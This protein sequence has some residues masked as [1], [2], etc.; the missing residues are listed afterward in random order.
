MQFSRLSYSW[1]WAWPLVRALLVFSCSPLPAANWT[2]SENEL[3]QS[4]IADM[5]S[6]RKALEQSRI[7]LADSRENATELSRLLDEA[8]LRV[9]RLS[10]QLQLWQEHSNELTQSL[11]RLSV[12]LATLRQELK[13]LTD[14]YNALSTLHTGYVTAVDKQILGLQRSRDVWRVVGLGAIVAA[15]IAGT[16]AAVR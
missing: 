14:S 1:R 4:M 9:S 7:A 11:E 12:E 16:I 3:W 8:R 6:A 10:A 5:L 2:P 15:V 13:R